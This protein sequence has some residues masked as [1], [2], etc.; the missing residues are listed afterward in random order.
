MKNTYN[1][2]IQ[3]NLIETLEKETKRFG[4]VKTV[5]IKKEF[6]F[7]SKKDFDFIKSLQRIHET[8]DNVISTYKNITPDTELP[9]DKFSKPINRFTK[10]NKKK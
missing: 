4:I 5:K 2:E 6:C 8:A 1:L 10:T 7:S 3:E 9:F